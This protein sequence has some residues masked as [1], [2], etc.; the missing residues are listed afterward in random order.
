MDA[1]PGLH[2]AWAARAM[3][4]C[5]SVLSWDTR[6][7]LSYPSHDSAPGTTA[8][9]DPASVEALCAALGGVLLSRA[10]LR[11]DPR[12]MTHALEALGGWPGGEAVI[13]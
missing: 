3:A 4:S 13:G 1:A 10:R 5:R 7:A 11:V 2:I 6:G 9:A 12:D 8:A